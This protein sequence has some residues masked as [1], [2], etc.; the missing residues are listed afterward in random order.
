MVTQVGDLVAF[1]YSGSAPWA[2]SQLV[3]GYAHH[4][5]PDDWTV[6]LRAYP[7]VIATLWDDSAWDVDTWSLGAMNTREKVA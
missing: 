2:S 4:I 5:T 7:A 3:G 1:A 6:D